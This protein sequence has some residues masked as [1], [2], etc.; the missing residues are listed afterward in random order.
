MFIFDEKEMVWN[1]TSNRLIKYCNVNGGLT[2]AVLS[3]T[4]NKANGVR[5]SI[6]Q[7]RAF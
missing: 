3:Q 2:S 6:Q 4:E 1:I 7:R 5:Y